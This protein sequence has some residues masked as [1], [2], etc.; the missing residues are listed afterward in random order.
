M[1]C[2][3]N[4][5][6]R[7]RYSRISTYQY[8]KGYCVIMAKYISIEKIMT[9]SNEVKSTSI[10]VLRRYSWIHFPIFRYN[11]WISI[12]EQIQDTARRRKGMTEGRL[13]RSSLHAGRYFLCN[14]VR[15]SPQSIRNALIVGREKEKHEPVEN[16]LSKHF[17]PLNWGKIS[18]RLCFRNRFS[19]GL[20]LFC[21]ISGVITRTFHGTM[22]DR[23]K[24]RHFSK[25]Y[26][27][28]MAGNG[29]E[30]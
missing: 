23:D 11:W 7:K 20:C 4:I 2:R 25:I 16:A 9:Q 6:L 3:L 29:P 15:W 28:L 18:R 14:S 19:S 5:C 12:W 22:L 26:D 1:N 13:A 24:F 10:V 8:A 30:M 21:V 27:S 17:S